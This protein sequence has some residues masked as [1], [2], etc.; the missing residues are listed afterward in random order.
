[1]SSDSPHSFDEPSAISLDGSDRDALAKLLAQIL[2]AAG[3]NRCDGALDG[4]YAEAAKWLYDQ[5]RRR[6]QHLPP[7]LFGE[8]AWDILLI[9]YWAQHSQRRLTVSAVCA[10]AGAP[11]TTAL[12]Y[13]EHLCRSGHI[14]KQPHPTDR[15]ISWLSLSNDAD[16]RIGH[17][18]EQLL[19][20]SPELRSEA[21]P[22]NEKA[23]S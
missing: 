5:R 2:N 3:S 7:E 20:A 21:G 8:P 6:E 13:I 19:K 15:R 14:V 12:R 22:L 9:L 1:M 23:G 10:S 16:Q 18:L 11:T 17:Y 4:G